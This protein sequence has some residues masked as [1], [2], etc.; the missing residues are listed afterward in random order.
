MIQKKHSM[1][2]ALML[3]VVMAMTVISVTSDIRGVEDEAYSRHERESNKSS[4]A[5][6]I[7]EQD[8][9]EDLAKDLVYRA[10]K[11]VPGLD[12]LLIIGELK[13]ACEEYNVFADYWKRRI[14]DCTSDVLKA[15]KID[16]KNKINSLNL[17]GIKNTFIA[18][19]K[20]VDGCPL[21]MHITCF[22]AERSKIKGGL[23]DMSTA[24]LKILQDH[25]LVNAK[26]QFR[27]NDFDVH[28]F[29]K[30]FSELFEDPLGRL[31]E[32]NLSGFKDAMNKIIDGMHFQDE[33]NKIFP[34]ERHIKENNGVIWVKQF[35]PEAVATQY[36]IEAITTSAQRE[37][38]CSRNEDQRKTIILKQ[39]E[40]FL[41]NRDAK[42]FNQFK[43][44]STY[45]NHSPNDPQAL[46]N[47]LTRAENKVLKI[48]NV[49]TQMN[50]SSSIAEMV[51]T[52]YVD[53][54][55]EQVLEFA[56]RSNIIAMY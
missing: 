17:D 6:P 37:I 25:G 29:L 22:L 7:P 36:A 14:D 43:A 39:Y 28:T 52:D 26:N 40:K 5:N 30:N 50:P 51:Q 15:V 31:T 44:V 54:L 13:K 27:K 2:F 53:S 18:Q 34:Q 16:M 48:Q 24:A 41:F 12:E 11:L 19:S 3:Q 46:E 42:F 4:R 9:G 32:D 23:Q 20:H 21:L 35:L 38:M 33:I 49:L 45:L 47:N 8:T 55:V 10:V 1:S 56:E